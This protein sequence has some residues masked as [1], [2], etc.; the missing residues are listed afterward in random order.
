[1]NKKYIFETL[2]KKINNTIF[3]VDKSIVETQQSANEHKGSIE[4]QYDSAK[5]EAQAMVMALSKRKAILIE[6]GLVIQKILNNSS[7]LKIPHSI[8]QIASIFTLKD[9]NEVTATYFISPVMG[10]EILDIEN[11]KITVL[12][13][14]SP[15]GLQVMKKE[16]DDDVLLSIQSVENQFYV[17]Y[18]S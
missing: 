10:G 12:S 8:I 11:S 13:P 1:M 15:L 9:E 7:L 5:E 16:V 3:I 18:I 6:H 2:L 14:T 4:S 17:S